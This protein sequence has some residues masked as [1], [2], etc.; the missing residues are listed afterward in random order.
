MQIS[1]SKPA[2]KPEAKPEVKPEARPEV[3]PEPVV[4]PEAKPETKPKVKPVTKPKAKQEAKPEVKP[5]VKPEAKPEESTH[6]TALITDIL[7]NTEM[8]PH[9][10]NFEESDPF[11]LPT[12]KS[13]KS[14]VMYD[15][16][17]IIDNYLKDKNEDEGVDALK[18]LHRSR[19]LRTTLTD[20]VKFVGDDD[21]HDKMS[22][23]D[24][25]EYSGKSHYQEIDEF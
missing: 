17:S 11:E 12:K 23:Y 24:T 2:V 25:E 9:A 22:Y 15:F 10:D 5:E 20:I 14:Y 7:K 4:E 18:N 16:E 21:K 3:K 6:D 8:K 13:E 19:Q 1:G